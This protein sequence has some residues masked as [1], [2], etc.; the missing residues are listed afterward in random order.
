MSVYGFRARVAISEGTY[1]GIIN[2]LHIVTQAKNLRKL[3]R[4]LEKAVELTIDGLVSHPEEA[5]YYPIK[6]N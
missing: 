5:K 6:L 3:K 1:S 2:K 4:R